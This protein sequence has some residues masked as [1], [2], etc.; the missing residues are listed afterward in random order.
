VCDCAILTGHRRVNV[1]V[2]HFEKNSSEFQVN[3]ICRRIVAVSSEFELTCNS[4]EINLENMLTYLHVPSAI[5]VSVGP[6]FL[7]KKLAGQCLTCLPIIASRL[8]KLSA[9]VI[10]TVLW[11]AY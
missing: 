8:L 7:S 6:F 5:F 3:P 9:V 1:M 10:P 2:L 4:L 11:I